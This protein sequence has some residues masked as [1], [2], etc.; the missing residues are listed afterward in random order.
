M[1][2]DLRLRVLVTVSAMAIAAPSHGAFM[3][4][5]H[6]P[7]T[8]V[9]TPSGLRQVYRVYAVFTDPGDR[10]VSWGS[11]P[12]IPYATM[13]RTLAC[14]NVPGSNFYNAPNGSTAPS[15][16]AVDAIPH[17]QWD[18]FARIG[19]SIADQGSGIAPLGPDMTTLSPGFPAFAMGNIWTTTNAAVFIAG[20]GPGTEQGLAGYAGDG[21]PQL[22][23]LMAQITTLVGDGLSIRVGSITW[24]PA[25][26]T[27]SQTAENLGWDPADAQGRCCRHDGVCFFSTHGGC[28]GTGNNTWLGCNSCSECEPAQ[29]CAGD[30]TGSGNVVNIDDLLAVIND[31]GGGAGNPADVNGDGSVNIDDLLLVINSWGPCR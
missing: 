4:V 27:Q 17:T 29:S 12:N 28:L 5:T 23:V 31:W 9:S 25:G 1:G 18:T 21:D 20:T 15:Q 3:G 11:I 6:S 22:R 2:I 13:F 26:S 19:V 16:K 10:L 30:V 14:T 24:I 8:Q 7:H